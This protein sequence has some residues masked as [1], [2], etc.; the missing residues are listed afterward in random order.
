MPGLREGTEDRE[1]KCPCC[2]KRVTK[3]HFA[4]HSGSAGGKAATGAKKARGGAEYYK[5][6]RAKRKAHISANTTIRD[7]GNA[8]PDSE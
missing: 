8:A 6:L 3:S 1:M 2:N 5:N 7:G 4:C